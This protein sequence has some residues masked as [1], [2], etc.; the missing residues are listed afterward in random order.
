MIP[1]FG[2]IWCFL[3]T[4]LRPCMGSWQEYH[5]KDSMP[6]PLDQVGVCL[7]PSLQSHLL[8]FVTSTCFVGRLY[9]IISKSWSS[10]NLCPPALTSVDKPCLNQIPLW[11]LP[12]RIFFCFQH[13]FYHLLVGILL[14]RKL[15]FLSPLFVYIRIN[16]WLPILFNWLKPLNIIIYFDVQIVSDWARQT[17]FWAGLLC[18]CHVPIILWVFPYFLAQEH[19]L[20][21][22]VLSLVSVLEST[23]STRAL[24]PLVKDSI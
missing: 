18:L 21:S 24:V 6:S 23:I 2:F 13:S 5:R 15:S 10:L 19:V 12:N 11:W 16:S 20:D 8:P 3:L 14:L 1:Q 4:R 17:P 22:F 9:E 7:A